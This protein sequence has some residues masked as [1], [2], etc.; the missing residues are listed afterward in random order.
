LLTGHPLGP[1]ATAGSQRLTIPASKVPE[2]LI[3]P[4]AALPDALAVA[5]R[6]R[7]AVAAADLSPL[8]APCTLSFGLACS[9]LTPLP[10]LPQ[11]ADQAL[12]QA[13]AH[14]RNRLALW[15]GPLT[16]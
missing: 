4:H 11:A 15:P 10:A 13:K 2:N 12:Y 16:P 7:A 8:P 5:E 3:L 6:L 1:L 14:G 9:R